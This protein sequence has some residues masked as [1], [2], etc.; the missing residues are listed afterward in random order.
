M[1]TRIWEW[2]MSDQQHHS[3]VLCINILSVI[4]LPYGYSFSCADELNDQF[5]YQCRFDCLGKC[6]SEFKNEKHLRVPPTSVWESLVSDSHSHVKSA[7][8]GTV[9]SLNLHCMVFQIPSIFFSQLLKIFCIAEDTPENQIPFSD[10]LCDARFLL[11][12]FIF[13]CFPYISWH[14]VFASFCDKSPSL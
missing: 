13:C 7:L 6:D 1:L 14:W 3:W 8:S 12:N 5:T 4:K 10:C 9:G 2:L 11:L